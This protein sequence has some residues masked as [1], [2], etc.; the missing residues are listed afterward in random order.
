M[1]WI[2]FIKSLIS[3]LHSEVSPNQIAGGVALGAIVGLA[4]FSA[5]H[6]FLVIFLILLVQVNIGAATFGAGIFTLV[7]LALDPIANRIGFYLLVDKESLTPMWTYLYNLPIVPFTRFY[8]T[9]VLGNFVLSL[10]L[11]VPVFFA[12]KIFIVQ[13]RAKFQ[14]RVE[15]WKIMKMFKL[16]SFYKFYEQY[17]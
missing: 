6:S 7:G 15:K 3:L 5:F 2:K 4:P 1:L 9:A 11:F 17:K 14:Q 8:N 10:I 16:S 13:Y 12:V